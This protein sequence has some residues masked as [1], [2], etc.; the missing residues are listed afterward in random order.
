MIP[1]AQGLIDQDQIV[2]ELGEIVLGQVAGRTHASDITFFKSVG[3]AAQDV[4]VAQ[5]A[6]TLAR[7][8]NV[9]TE[10]AL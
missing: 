9:G 5:L 1:R 8:L 6:Y 3:N 4:A 2:A 7:E 10:V